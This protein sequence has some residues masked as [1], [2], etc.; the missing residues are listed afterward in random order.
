VPLTERAGD[1]NVRLTNGTVRE[2][3]ADL[4][5]VWASGETGFMGIVADPVTSRRFYTCQGFE[6]PVTSAHDVR[7]IAWTVDAAYTTATRVADPLFGGI[8]AT[9]GRHGGCRLRFGTDGHLWVGTGD[10]ATG[11]NPQDLTS[12]GGKILRVDENSGAGVADNPFF[13][14]SNANTRRIYNYGHRNVQ[15]LAL[16]P[17][18]QMWTVEHGTNCDDEVNLA[19]GGGNYGWDPVPGYDESTPMTDFGKFPNAIGAAWS[20]GCPT[21]ATSGADWL[22]GSQWGTW[23]GTLAVATLAG[24]SLR[25]MRFAGN[26]AF[27]GVDIPP[28]LDGDYGRL[29]TAQLG[30]DGA[31]YLTTSNGSNDRILR[32]TPQP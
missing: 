3:T 15:G 23:N 6:N 24:T 16:R 28:E 17:N 18:G 27:Q 8:P 25:V 31:L 30:P 10:A 32:V 5:D 20:S 1:L 21:I 7:V 26:G 4:D 22:V 14:S 11:T 2:L 19:V 13:G 12:L 29:R 9:S